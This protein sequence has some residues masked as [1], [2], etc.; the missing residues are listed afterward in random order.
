MCHG[1]RYRDLTEKLNGKIR[2]KAM[3][4]ML[5]AKLYEEKVV[6][7]ESEKLESGKTSFLNEI[8]TPLATDKLLFLTSFDADKNFMDASKNIRNISVK[9]PHEISL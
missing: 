7:I 4:I 3:Q 9:N 2:I 1:P 5:A 6:M 8:I